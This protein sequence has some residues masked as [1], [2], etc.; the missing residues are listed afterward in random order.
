MN[1]KKAVVQFEWIFAII[2]GALILFLA[3]YATTNIIS[4]SRTQESLEFA[5]KFSILFEPLETGLGEASSSVIKL[6]DNTRIYN[7]CYSDGFGRQEFGTV[8]TSAFYKNLEEPEYFLPVKNKYIFSEKAA[9]GKIF[10]LF[11]KPLYLP[12][13]IADMSYFSSENFCFVNPP[14]EVEEEIFGLKLR[15][16]NIS[17]SEINC[18][19]ESKKVCFDA[20]CDISVSGLCSGCSDKYGFGSVTKDGKS[21]YFSG[22]SLMYAAIFSSKDI[23][24]CNVKRVMY[25]LAWL[26]SLYKDKAR[27]MDKVGCEIGFDSSLDVLSSSALNLNKTSN[28]AVVYE[29]GSK[30]DKENENA[31]CKFY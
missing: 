17:D 5:K 16:V 28:L 22:A 27:L 24:E 14:E 10:Y 6:K 1:K 12:F 19:A 2:V 18:L 4:T 7:K 30:L 21:V 31:L 9:E 23:Y 25:K 8:S 15:N 3:I 29:Q 13:K 11:S 26:S 20:I